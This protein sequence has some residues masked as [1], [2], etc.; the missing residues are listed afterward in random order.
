MVDEAHDWRR[1]PVRR[2]E[3]DFVEILDEDVVRARRKQRFVVPARM[4]RIGVPRA[5]AID[6]YPVELSPRR[7]AVPTGA[8]ERHLVAV[9]NETPEDLV[10]ML[11]RTA[12]LR[13]LAILPID[14]A[15]A[16]ARSA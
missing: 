13:I 16:H 15:D 5:D 11:F 9:A 12:R 4:Q 1:L 7:R 10:Q 3:R 14:N 6:L 8:H 2:P